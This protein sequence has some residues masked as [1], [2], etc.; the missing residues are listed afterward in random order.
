LWILLIINKVLVHIQS[1]STKLALLNSNTMTKTNISAKF[2]VSS[3]LIKKN[4]NQ[5]ITFC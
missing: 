4:F 3:S 2:A 1:L 5:N